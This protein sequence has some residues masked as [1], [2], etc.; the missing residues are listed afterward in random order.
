M[1][2]NVIIGNASHIKNVPGRKTDVKDS[3]WIAQ[4]HRFGLI[5]PYFV[6]EGILLSFEISKAKRSPDIWVN[7][8]SKVSLKFSDQFL[9]YLDQLE[10]DELLRLPFTLSDSSIN[11]GWVIG[12]ESMSFAP[13]I[14]SLIKIRFGRSLNVLL[15]LNLEKPLVLPISIQLS[16][17]YTPPM[18]LSSST[19]VSTIKIGWPYF[20][21][22]SLFRR[23]RFNANNLEPKLGCRNLGK[24]KNLQLFTIN[25]RRFF[26]RR[27]FQPGLI[28]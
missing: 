21:N 25:L 12:L 17:R 9:E 14:K 10:N 22:Q 11:I 26:L 20:S 1:G 19:K 28:I 8:V 4:L 5:R 2:L 24:I 7:L 16:A 3:H 18:N 15:S 27:S 13:G 6:P 23:L